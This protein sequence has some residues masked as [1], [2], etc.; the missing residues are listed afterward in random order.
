MTEYNSYCKFLLKED[1]SEGKLNEASILSMDLS[2]N[3]LS[4]KEFLQVNAVQLRLA[5]K[6]INNF[7][8]NRGEISR[9]DWIDVLGDSI[10]LR[11]LK[12]QGNRFL[13]CR[14][15]HFNWSDC[16]L[17][18]SVSHRWN[19][20]KG[21]FEKC[22]FKDSE[23]SR[24]EMA[25]VFFNQCRFELTQG[26]GLLGFRQGRLKSCLFVDCYISGP[27]FQDIDW[28]DCLFVRCS[29]NRFSPDSLNDKTVYFHQCQGMDIVNSISEC[30]IDSTA[31]EMIHHRISGETGIG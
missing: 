7:T 23:V 15:T 18:G 27:F 4:G 19:L 16:D 21:A 24:F 30:N 22:R 25:N 28:D 5:E 8:W 31:L 13:R 17:N 9:S 6:E 11:G 10:C 14:W 26:E 12:L 29:F 1:L 2:A 20:E 3:E